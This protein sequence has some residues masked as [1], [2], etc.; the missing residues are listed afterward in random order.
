MSRE[1][2]KSIHISLVILHE[3]LSVV[4]N[5]DEKNFMIDIS[6]NEDFSNTIFTLQANNA[7]VNPR[8]TKIFENIESFFYVYYPYGNITLIEAVFTKMDDTQFLLN[9]HNATMLNEP[10]KAVEITN[11]SLTDAAAI[12]V[13]YS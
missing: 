13:I 2:E 7:Q 1:N 6:D 11:K 9:L 12:K 10:F 3:T 8:S 5:Q 4:R